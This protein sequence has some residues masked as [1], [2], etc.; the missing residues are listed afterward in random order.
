MTRLMMLASAMGLLSACSSPTAS[1]LNSPADP[2]L[3]LRTPAYTPVVGGVK[4]YSVVEPM[5][6]IEQNRRVGPAGNTTDTGN[7]A[8]AAA[9]RGR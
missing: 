3:G 7:D 6:W 9:R 8:A 5:D 4:S 2:T 1:L